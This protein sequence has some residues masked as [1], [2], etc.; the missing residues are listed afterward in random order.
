MNRGERR[1]QAKAARSRAGGV[2][3][4][5][6]QGT[7]LHEVGRLDQAERLYRRALAAAPEH[8]H[9][10][11]YLGLALHE[12]GRSGDAVAHLEAA[13]RAAPD[14]PM[15]RYNL[16]EALFADGRPSD[17]VPHYRASAR[18]AT[19]VADV[20]ARLGAAL[21]ASGD[22]AA[23]EPAFRTALDLAP[24]DPVARAELALALD[25]LGRT[26]EAAREMESALAGGAEPVAAHTR[27]SAMYDRLGHRDAAERHARMAVEADPR[28]PEALTTLARVLAQADTG[29]LDEALRLAEAAVAAAPDRAAG[30]ATLGLVHQVAGRGD[31]AEKSYRAAL[32][33][34]PGHAMAW[35]GL[36]NMPRLEGPPIDE[37]ELR[38]A[39]AAP[40]L[41]DHDRATLEFALGRSCERRGAHDEAFAAYAAANRRRAASEPF[42]SETYAASVERIVAT[43]TADFFAERGGWGSDDPRPIF[44]VGMPRSGTSLVEQVLASHPAMYG[45][46][47]REDLYRLAVVASER[48]GAGYPESVAA[49]G[50]DAVRDLARRHLAALDALAPG[51]RRVTDKMPANFL[52]LAMIALLFPGARVVHCR[53]DPGDT[54]LSCFFQDFSHLRFSF[55]LAW[56]G[57][58]M[59]GYR[60]LMAHWAEV[61]PIP[62]MTVDYEAL[63]ADPERWS[64]ALID[65]AGLPWDDACLRPHETER[66]VRTASVWQVR[67]PV[68][69]SSVGRWKRYEAQMAPFFAALGEAP[70]DGGAAA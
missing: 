63:V 58:Y 17:A 14:D 53:R 43:F 66:A 2:D 32:A 41:D 30:H 64:R 61:L 1:R 69:G 24:D 13:A 31:L 26:A 11:H 10:R 33:L 50:R 27:L 20:H 40:E 5:L 37:A 15:F 25:V 65:F 28:D 68:Y 49:L 52:R 7:R 3:A 57:A 60:R 35:L 39:L 4:L 23:A 46:G 21:L 67:Q 9:V 29:D 6:A 62:L 22:A 54:A 8:P 19:D 70:G 42:D 59:R 56:I 44:V 48:T 47:E 12:Q 38:A 36:L 55:D 51:A 16:A 18:A 34:D 45:G